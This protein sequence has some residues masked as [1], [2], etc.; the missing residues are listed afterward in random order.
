[1]KD[2]LVTIIHSMFKY[3]LN[4]TIWS[5][6]ASDI[7]SSQSEASATPIPRVQLVPETDIRDINMSKVLDLATKMQCLNLN[8]MNQQLEKNV[9][10]SQIQPSGVEVLAVKPTESDKSTSGLSP[11]SSA[12]TASQMEPSEANSD[13]YEEFENDELLTSHKMNVISVSE[14]LPSTVSINDTQPGEFSSEYSGRMSTDSGHS[15]RSNN[16]SELSTSSSMKS[17]G[18]SV[19]ILSIS[20]DTT[21]SLT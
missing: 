7:N 1:M 19:E 5:R 9:E 3:I 14:S 4:P 18:D 17:S 13:S 15:A 16:Q 11:T 8:L 12:E 21:S 2:L 20:S 10:G 6:V